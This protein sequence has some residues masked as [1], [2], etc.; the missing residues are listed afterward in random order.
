M[1][2]Q[3]KNRTKAVEQAVNQ[4]NDILDDVDTA[5][6]YSAAAAGEAQKR[7]GVRFKK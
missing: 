2:S 6:N 1:A 7:A 5:L 4:R 3:L